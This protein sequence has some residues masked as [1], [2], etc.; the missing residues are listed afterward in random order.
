MADRQISDLPTVVT[1]VGTELFYCRQS[2]TDKSVLL[3]Q[4]NT[5]FNDEFDDVSTTGSING[6]DTFI[7]RRSAATLKTL[8]STLKSYVLDTFTIGNSSGEIPVSN[9]TVNTNLN[10]DL[11]DGLNSG[12]AS[13]NVPVS[14]GTLNTNLNAD[15]HD[16]Y[17][18]TTASGA[19]TVAVR[20]GNQSLTIGGGL[21]RNG[22]SVLN[23]KIIDIGDWNMD[24]TSGIQIAHG[25]GADY[26]KIRNVSVIIRDDANTKVYRITY[27]I[28]GT[29][30]GGITFI[31]NT[32]IQ[33]TRTSG[34]GFDNAQF[35]STSYNRGWIT[36]EYI[37]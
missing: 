3:S 29:V 10:A 2:A 33:L 5:F 26:V 14:N 18:A 20:D 24:T 31:D 23:C 22:Q 13:G 12:N 36:F 37:D 25:L 16:G 11:L 35:D 15:L 32:N 8:A 21:S 27:P 30:S 1:L 6:T 4:L 28:G 19:N 34:A 7:L 17:H 9:G